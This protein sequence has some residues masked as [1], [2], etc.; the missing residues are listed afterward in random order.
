MRN[1]H[2]LDRYRDNGPRAT[3]AYAGAPQDVFG[4]F[5]IP[6]PVDREIL[7]VLAASGGGWDHVSI[8]RPRRPCIWKEMEYIKHM[9]F[10]ENEVAMQLHVPAK[11]HVNIH[12][13]CLHLWRPLDKEIPLPPELY[14]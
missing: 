9:F 14:V 3:A 2:E 4:V 13:F 11:N 6:S 10:K 1:L 8:S 7:L 5:R 12:P